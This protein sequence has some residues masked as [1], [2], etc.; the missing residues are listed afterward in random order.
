MNSR[1][2]K[3]LQ[4]NSLKALQS[5]ITTTAE[6]GNKLE[7]KLALHLGGYQ[8]RQKLLRGKVSEA[9]EA[10][11]TAERSL[12]AFRLLQ[13]SEEAAIGSRLEGLREE[14][15]FITRRERE[16]QELYRARKAELDELVERGQ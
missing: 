13:I 2:H 6:R 4:T 5:E 15:G 1:T 9:Y 3:N 7:K 14:V 12:E 10:Q 16:A 11:L 8:K